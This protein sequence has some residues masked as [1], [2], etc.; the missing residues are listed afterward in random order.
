MENY[1]IEHYKPNK[2]YEDIQADLFSK[3]TG[4][5]ISGEELKQRY[6]KEKKDPNFLRYAFNDSGEP[7]AYIQAS[8][9]TSS[10]FYLGY[11]WSYPH[12][13]PEVQEKLF[14][15][16]LDY[17][18]GKNPKEIQYWINA[19]W[20]QVV[21]FFTQRDFKLRKKGFEYHFD[22]IELS[23]STYEESTEFTARL[24]TREDLETLFEIGKID[25][26]L[27]RAGLSSEFLKDYFANKVL[28]DGHCILVFKD[29]MIVCA[30]APLQEIT[31]DTPKFIF[32]RFTA[33]RPGFE[34]AWPVLVV[35]IAKECV[36]IGWTKPLHINVESESKLAK[37]LK[38]FNPKIKD[39]YSLYVLEF[40]KNS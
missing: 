25:K 26:G 20:T 1:R 4:E 28:K 33:T 36:A 30:S 6:K 22:M 21:E 39:S 38:Q 2:G 40:K 24:A 29:S 34:E 5:I 9:V 37:I 15:D 31:P 18:K 19:E 7:L 35:E 11:P 14:T 13:P 12:C 8:Q 10:V 23:K 17:I 32:L 3:N 27:Q 16:M